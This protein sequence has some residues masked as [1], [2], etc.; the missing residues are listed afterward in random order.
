MARIARV[1]VPDH[2]HHVTQRGNRRQ[3]I[4]FS[5]HDYQLYID[6]L[7]KH[8]D[9]SGVTIWAYCLM[10]NHVHLVAVP[11]DETGLTSCLSQTHR[12]YAL[13]INQRYEWKGH[14]WQERFFSFVMD[15]AHLFSAVR[16]IECNPVRAKLCDE[17]SDWLWSSARAHLTGVSDRL[18]KNKP[19]LGR[20]DNWKE[21][22]SGGCYDDEESI[23][24]HTTSGRPSSRVEF[25]RQ[26]ERLTGRVLQKR[27]PGPKRD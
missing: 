15:E 10:P 1:V 18:L 24:K 23:R 27:K 17:P 5:A 20:V 26:I 8:A 25:L 6:L 16:Y 22:L 21:Y 14:L 11:S 4:F 19:M 7:A 9:K 2:P 12:S 13:R 3:Q